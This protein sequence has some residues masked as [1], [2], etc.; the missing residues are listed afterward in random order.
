MSELSLSFHHLVVPLRAAFTNA[1]TTI[2]ERHIGL[3][4]LSDG[5][6]TG[7]G[8]ASPYP[9]LDPPIASLIAAAESG[10]ASPLLHTAVS[11]ARADLSARQ[12][13]QPLGRQFG[14]ERTTVP[15]CLAVGHGDMA[16]EDVKT[17]SSRGVTRFKIK[18]A[19]GQ[20]D[21]VRAIREAFPD[22]V[23]GVDANGSFDGTTIEQLLVLREADLAFIE[24][25]CDLTDRALVDRVHANIDAPVFADESV[26]T[27]ADAAAIAATDHIDGLVL[28]PAR[29]GIVG[30]VDAA[31]AA[32]HAG[33]R[34]RASGLLES[35]IGRAYSN[36]LAAHR[37]A[38]VS[39]VAPADWFLQRDVAAVGVVDASVEIPAGPGIGLVPDESVLDRF[40]I[41]AYDL[42]NLLN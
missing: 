42:R 14:I 2:T 21:H 1:A 17:A 27:I 40:R 33:K 4:E 12:A 6:N 20:V 16:V 5:S 18:V 8:E 29:L 10:R 3:V 34:W 39:D 28:K 32:S 24:Q 23:I 9:S 19:P 7:W 26:R 15:I 13:A 31:R 30:A 25:P 41:G 37:D 11:L 22:H 38:F 35:G 36:L